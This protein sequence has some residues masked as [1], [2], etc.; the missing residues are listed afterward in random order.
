MA[1]SRTLKLLN[2]ILKY[3]SRLWRFE[4]RISSSLI[5]K[6]VLELAA[7]VIEVLEPIIFIVQELV[8]EQ[9]LNALEQFFRGGY[10]TE[11]A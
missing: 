9:F 8:Q 1:S 10:H 5:K 2:F 4:N 6:V 3:R 11:R 7:G